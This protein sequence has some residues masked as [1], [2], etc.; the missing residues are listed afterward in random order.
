MAAALVLCVVLII[1]LLFLIVAQGSITF[2]QRPVERVTLASGEV[3]LGMPTR[4]ESFDP[5]RDVAD[6]IERVKGAAGLP[7][8]SL[9]EAGRPRRRLYQV[10]NRDLGQ[11]PFR[12]VSFYEVASIDRPTWAVQVERDAWGLWLGE[13]RALIEQR[14]VLVP[15]GHAVVSAESIE[16]GGVSRSVTREAVG[17]EGDGQQRVRERVTLAEGPDATWAALERL[18]PEIDATQAKINRIN[19]YEL[20]SNSASIEAVR[21]RIREAELDLEDA[22]AGRVATMPV[23]RFAGSIAVAAGLIGVAAMLRRNWAA[24]KPHRPPVWQRVAMAGM[25]IGAAMIGLDAMLER[26]WQERMTVER[27]AEIKAQG[28]AERVAL[29]ADGER[30][31]T[32]MRSLEAENDRY[33]IVIEAPTTGGARFAPVR[34]TLPDE[35]MKVSQLVRMVPANQ[36]T[37]SGKVEVY[38]DRWWELLTDDPRESNTEGGVFPVLFGTV[39]MTLLLSVIVVP[40]GVLAALY[41]REYAKQGVLISVI[42]VAVNNLAGVPSIVYG[43]FGL[44]FFCYTVGGYIDA[45]PYGGETVER[46]STSQ[47]GGMMAVLG[48]TIVSALAAGWLGTPTPGTETTRTQR[49]LKTLMAMLWLGAVGLAV[50]LLATTPYFNGFFRERASA[51]MGTKGLLWG[52]LTLA[53][54]TLPVVIVATEEAITAVPKT[55]REGSYGCGASKWQTIR[56]I[57]LPGAMP[58]IMTGMILAMARGAGE[59]APLMLVGAVKLAPELPM[60]GEFP[61]VHLERSFMHLGFHIYDLGFQSPDSEAAKPLVWTTTLVL[62]VVVVVL[63]LAAIM[64]RARLRAKVRSNQF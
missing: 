47:W 40:L 62:I 27:L 2:W 22:Q 33:R 20:G 54:L 41:M 10:G 28:D 52:A 49:Y 3:F 39:M 5:G 29:E 9:D 59:V 64:I 37:W 45:G 13:P 19:K 23:W 7:A 15:A 56:R 6:E 48:V 30:I 16:V 14:E 18:R 38:F 42:R 12:W 21:R 1:G 55:M 44:G 25:C 4:E 63:N 11:E 35:P 36:L 61:F 31:M 34:S 24:R 8:G 32:S 58:G 26:P 50:W 17:T 57:V 43:V 46:V 53:I 51:T 60:S